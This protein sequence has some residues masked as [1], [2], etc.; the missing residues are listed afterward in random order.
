MAVTVQM[1]FE[2]VVTEMY[3]DAFIGS[4]I[5]HGTTI[6]QFDLRKLDFQLDPALPVLLVTGG[7]Q[8]ARR[9]NQVIVAALPQL[10][11]RCQ[12]LH[13][14]GEYTY[15]ETRDAAASQF[16]KLPALR[17]RYALHAY[18][19]TEMPAALAASDVV[20]CRSGAATLAELAIMGRPSLL[21]PLPPGFG[22]S[23]FSTGCG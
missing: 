7:S 4:S 12:V 16:E 21:I 6:I 1:Q 3:E 11:P 15:E 22:I 9:L 17:P 20:L 19:S 5:E 23:T 13:V 8:G 18:L 2:S 10:L 14:S